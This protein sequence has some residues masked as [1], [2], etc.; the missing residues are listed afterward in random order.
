MERFIGFVI[1]L[2]NEELCDFLDGDAKKFFLQGGCYEFAKIIKAYIKCQIVINT[3]NTHC[4][5]LYDG[6]I[7]DASNEIDSKSFNIASKEDIKYIE[8]RMGIPE[9]HFIKGKTVSEY[10]IDEIKKCNIGF[11][12][13]EIEGE[14]R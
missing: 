9:K 1:D 2:A 4:A 13:K 14:E 11:L 6:K 5:V 10:L 12:I 8:E 7:Y 3:D